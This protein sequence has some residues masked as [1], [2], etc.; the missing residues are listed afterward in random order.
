MKNKSIGIWQILNSEIITDIIGC[1]NF[2]FVIFDLEH[3]LHDPNSVQK[4]LY[5]A[6]SQALKSFARVPSINYIDSVK[7]VDTGIDGIIIPHIEN[8]SDIEMIKKIYLTKS[9]GGERSI[10]PFVPRLDFG[11]IKKQNI[12]PLIGILIE[13][14][15]GIN[16]ANQLISNEIVDFVYFGAYDLSIENNIDGD[17]FNKVIIKKLKLLLKE[18]QKYKKQVMAICRDEKELSILVELG[19]ALPV[20]SVDTSILKNSLNKFQNKFS[21][22]KTN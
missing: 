13:S 20:Y 19:V 10:S 3:G 14:N 12:N 2:D 18:S 21:N 15:K 7:L 9:P 6:K 4:C 22:L 5:A 11:N 16:N 8:I 1:S 17:I